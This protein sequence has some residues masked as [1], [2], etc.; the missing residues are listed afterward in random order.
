MLEKLDI[1]IKEVLNINVNQYICDSDELELYGLD[2]LNF[3]NLV[4]KIE[5]V[6]DIKF[7]ESEILY[8]N[9]CNKNSIINSI[10][11]ACKR[12]IYNDI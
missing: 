10:E 6:F 4:I 9:F 7:D 3:I 2:S 5:N 8:R 11:I 12:R 1:V